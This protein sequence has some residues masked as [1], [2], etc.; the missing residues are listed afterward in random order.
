MQAPGVAHCVFESPP[1]SRFRKRVPRH[2]P[3]YPF[4]P[5]VESLRASAGASPPLLGTYQGDALVFLVVSRHMAYRRTPFAVD[6][7]YHCYNRGV[8]KRITF[9]DKDDYGRFVQL[10]YLANSSASVQRRNMHAVSTHAVMAAPLPDRLVSIAAYSLMP[11]HFHLLIKEIRD[12]G[13]VTFMQK[14]GT[15][16][17]MYFN[18]KNKRTGN[19]FV[20]P[21]RSKHINDDAYLQYCAHYIHCNP[22]ELKE[23]KWKDESVRNLHGLEKFLNEYSYSSLLEYQGTDRSERRILG[24]DGFETLATAPMAVILEQAQLYHRNFIT[25]ATPW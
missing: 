12:D 2:S 5:C 18:I 24:R 20:K 13:I 8:D 16:Y 25:K 15:A 6:E 19:L 14:L 4:S 23:P 1:S 9:E 22:I 17:T 10:L 21:F 7:W 3:F 11:N